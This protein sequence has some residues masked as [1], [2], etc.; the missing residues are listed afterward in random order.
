MEPFVIENLLRMLCW[1]GEGL[2]FD[3][4]YSRHEEDGC[5]LCL[6]MALA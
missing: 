1:S 3:R 2:F 4:E 6:S 5:M